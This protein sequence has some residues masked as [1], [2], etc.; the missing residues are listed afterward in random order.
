M[1]WVC[2]E[3]TSLHGCLIAAKLCQFPPFTQPLR[4]KMKKI[5][6]HSKAPLKTDHDDCNYPAQEIISII[7]PNLQGGEEGE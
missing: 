4:K 6:L 3:P 5:L 2:N 7:T 1:E